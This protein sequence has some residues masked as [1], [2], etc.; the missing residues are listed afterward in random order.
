[1]QEIDKK[2]ATYIRNMTKWL[3]LKKGEKEAKKMLKTDQG[4]KQAMREYNDAYAVF[5]EK[6]TNLMGERR[7]AKDFFNKKIAGDVYRHIRVAEQ[8]DIWAKNNREVLEM[9]E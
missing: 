6:I 8:N 3:K 5:W 2:T 1:M 4:I 9:L 7:L